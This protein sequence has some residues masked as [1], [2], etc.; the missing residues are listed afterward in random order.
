MDLWEWIF[1]W[2]V[3]AVVAI[4]LVVSGNRD[5]ADIRDNEDAE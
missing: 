1:M 4:K 5:Q 3:F 2:L